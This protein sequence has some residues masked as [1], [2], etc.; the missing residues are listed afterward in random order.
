MF[1]LPSIPTDSLYKFLFIGGLVL[2][3]YSVYTVQNQNTRLARQKFTVDSIRILQR[4]Y[5]KL[6]SIVDRAHLINYQDKQKEI[7]DADKLYLE[8]IRKK[9]D[10]REI[11]IIDEQKRRYRAQINENSKRLDSLIKKHTKDVV[12]SELRSTELNSILDSTESNLRQANAGILLGFLLLIIGGALWYCKIQKPQDR[13]Q[14]IQL[15]IAEI[16]LTRTKS[17]KPN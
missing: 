14:S 3:I 10:P 11:E 9:K 2:M 12:Q 15:E 8:L 4:T 5:F 16:E 6:D 1:S 17:T 13:L 7:L